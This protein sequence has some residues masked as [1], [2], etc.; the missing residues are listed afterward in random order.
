MTGRI[1]HLVVTAQTLAA[2]TAH[3]EAALALGLG[4]GGAHEK[5]GTHNRLL[6]LG[7]EDY[8]EAIAPDP[9]A[10][11]PAHPRWFGLDA[12]G[13]PRLS[14]WVL[15]VEDMEAALAE[16]PEEIGPAVAMERG[17]YR[18]RITVPGAGGPPFGGMFPALIAWD[19]PPPAPALPDAGA[20]LVRLS[21]SHPR[22][23][24]LGWALS[25]LTSD[26]RLVVH[27]GPAGLSALI[28]TSAGERMLT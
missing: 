27:E 24:A 25:M 7:A 10:T 20:R 11:A 21:V 28:H 14:H 4:A 8:L 18:W 1:D 23:G 26:D 2:A 19:T 5:M 15:R 3:A 12:P 6:S 13:A 17:P 16:A 9:A 22:A